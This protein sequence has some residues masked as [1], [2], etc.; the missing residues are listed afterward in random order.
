[1]FHLKV[2]WNSSDKYVHPVQIRIDLSN[3]Q[4]GNLVDRCMLR[5]TMMCSDIMELPNDLPMQQKRT[6]KD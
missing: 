4:M 1:M 2:N 3:I 6:K 5:Y